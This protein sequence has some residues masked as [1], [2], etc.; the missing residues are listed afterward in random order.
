MNQSSDPSLSPF[1]LAYTPALPELLS[2]LGC[3]IVVSTYQ[4]GKVIFLSPLNED[5]IIQL[6]RTF[7]KA[8]GI[9]IHDDQMVVA[10][11]DQVIY[12][13][14]STQL[15]QFYPKKPNTYDGMFLPRMTYHTGALDVHD[16]DFCHDGIYAVNTNFSCI[17]KIDKDHSFTPVWKPD[18]IQKITAGDHCHLNGMA[19]DRGRIKYVTAFAKTDT[20]R[21]WKEN[22]LETGV[23]IDYESKKVI[24][25]G[26]SMPHSPR[27]YNGKLYVLTS[28]NGELVEIDRTTLS[29]KVICK[30]DGFV[31]GL[32]F[33]N[34]FAFIGLSKLRKN[35]STFA[36][37]PIASQAK[38]AGIVVVHLDT[39]TVVGNLHY[40]TS[41]DEIYDVQILPDLI[42]PNILNTLTEDHKLAV[43]TPKKTFWGIKKEK[44]A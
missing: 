14:N 31:R 19:V 30:I 8:M 37:L 7:D 12:L 40:N 42:R 35:S 41:V 20:P 13:K 27:I 1:S 44:K 22:I 39:G 5:K 36:H 29:Q 3:T 9:A 34:G 10:C 15:G 26:L 24:V 6:P 21:Q 16:I 11:R 25:D 43:S 28:G 33:Y 2:K 17:I 23:L 18:F 38:K 4:A 32:S